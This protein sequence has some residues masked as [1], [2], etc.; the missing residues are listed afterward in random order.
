MKALS[1]LLHGSVKMWDVGKQIDALCN[2]AFA[3]MEFKGVSPAYGVTGLL[4][5]HPIARRR[6]FLYVEI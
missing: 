1:Y 6:I 2:G 5:P 4:F 3:C